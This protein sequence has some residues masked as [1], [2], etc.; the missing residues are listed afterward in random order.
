[1]FGCTKA[2]RLTLGHEFEIVEK[3]K[4]HE[5][6][7]ITLPE[8]DIQR[9][10]SESPVDHCSTLEIETNC[11]FLKNNLNMLIPPDC[12]LDQLQEVLKRN[13]DNTLPCIVYSIINDILSDTVS[14]VC[15]YVSSIML[16]YCFQNIQEIRIIKEKYPDLPILFISVLDNRV[17][18]NTESLTESEQHLL[19]NGDGDIKLK[20]FNSVK[21]QLLR[22][23]M[24][25]N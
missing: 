11:L 19:E 8:E 21:S 20:K 1:M 6:V 13:L 14:I 9:G 16:L 7:W 10:V 22:L 23:G 17:S 2:L 24:F 5:E 12:S 25:I 3:L 4:A 18:S 15:D